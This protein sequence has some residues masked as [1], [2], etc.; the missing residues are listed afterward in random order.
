MEGEFNKLQTSELEIKSRRSCKMDNSN[1]V[2]E[3]LQGELATSRRHQ[4]LTND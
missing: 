3:D 1:R 2:S 4:G